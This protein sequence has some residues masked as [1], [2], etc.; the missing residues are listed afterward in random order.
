[1]LRLLK[2]RFRNTQ[3]YIKLRFWIKQINGNRILVEWEKQG[4]PVPPPHIVK[5]LTIKEY[6]EKYKTSIFVETGTYLGDMVC[7]MKDYFNQIYS[8]ELSNE[9]YEMAKKRFAGEK[10]IQLIHGDSGTEL[11][12]IID[13]IDRP[14]LFW[15]DGHYSGGATAQGDIDTPIL[16][17][18]T[19]IFSSDRPHVVIIDDA[20]CFGIDP[21]YP[22]KDELREFVLSKKP[23]SSI[24]IEHNSIRI[25]PLKINFLMSV[26]A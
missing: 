26:Q 2:E 18:L 10:K 8:I 3:I 7:A 4:R 17:E 15:L 1:M 13:T 25:T 22:S 14:A 5:Q 20:H 11:K 9:F 23:A 12:K 16:S 24:E 19:H 21:A 6:A